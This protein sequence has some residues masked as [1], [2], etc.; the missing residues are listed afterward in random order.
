MHTLK[1]ISAV[2]LIIGIIVA[3]G[4]I[5][6]NAFSSVSDKLDT[7]ITK[8]DEAATKENWSTAEESL[9]KMQVDWSKNE[10]FWA[11][12]VDHMEIDNIESTMSRLSKFIKSRDKSLTLGE[13]A[14]LHLYVK[15]IPQKES[16][17]I[18]NIL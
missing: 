17:N 18:S 7:H 14:L 10:K 15:H 5:S 8:I 13:S 4:I 9:N 2:V 1:T 12:L 16:F 3:A 6:N 11:I